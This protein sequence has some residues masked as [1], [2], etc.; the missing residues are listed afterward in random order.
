MTK[1]GV[2]V[3]HIATLRQAREESFPDPIAL[4]K[5]A[6][7]GGADGIVCHL[8]ED[9]RHI[10]D[11]DVVLLRKLSTR[12]DLEMAATREMLRFALKIKP[13]MVTLVPEKRREITTEGGLDAAGQLKQLKLYVD[14]LQAAGI[15]V[16]LFVDPEVKQIEAAAKLRARFVEI[17]TGA[18]AR[19]GSLGKIKSIV[20]KAVEL[21]LRVNAGHGLDYNNVKPIAAI[22]E[23]EELNIGFSIIAR[24]VVVGMRQAVKEMKDVIS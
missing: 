19:G 7:A 17:H 1:L 8:R 20:N 21:G 2:N 22:P 9:R 18:Y 13:E 14:K 5:E 16:S 15:I 3:D 24:S 4:A 11:D 6:I 23:V 10:K 12:L